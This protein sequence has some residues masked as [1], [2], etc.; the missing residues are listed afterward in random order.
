MGDEKQG[1]VVYLNDGNGKF[2]EGMTIGEKTVAPCSIAVG[3][4]NRDGKAD[5]VIGYALTQGS[6]HLNDGSGRRFDQIRFGD[7]MGSAYGIAL[8]DVDSNGDL[9]IV[10]GRSDAPNTIYYAKR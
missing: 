5:I 1:S 3:D 6:I 9:D 2:G 7:G 10:V 8:G 4:M